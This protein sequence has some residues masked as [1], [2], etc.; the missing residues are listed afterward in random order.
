VPELNLLDFLSADHQ[1][2]LEAALAPRVIEVSQHLSV[3]RDFLYP[4]ISH[5]AANGKAIVADLRHAER[6]LEGCL[7]EFER[8][9]TPEHREQ[10]EAAI[11]DHITYQEEL[12]T[13]LRDVVPESALLTAS[14]SIALSI[15]G[16]PT[17]AHRLLGEGG[18]IGEVVEDI[19]S[20]ADHALDHL[21]SKKDQTG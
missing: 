2:L 19:T 9:A 21:H 6:W 10:L 18:L 14:E 15:G 7:R 3:E 13:R 20:A 12:F 11:G 4:A 8:G 16:A 1:N 5:H 17:H